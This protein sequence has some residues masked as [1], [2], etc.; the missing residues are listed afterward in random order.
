M[1]TSLYLLFTFISVSLSGCISPYKAVT[2]VG[3]SSL[4]TF[5]REAKTSFLG[6]ST[7]F[8]YFPESIE[9]NIGQGLTHG[10]ELG[11][12]SKG[13]PFLSN[14]NTSQL[15]VESTSTFRIY[16]RNGIGQNKCDTVTE[17]KTEAGEE[18]KIIAF[19]DLGLAF[20]NAG[21]SAK[22][23]K[24]DLVDN[25]FEEIGFSFHESC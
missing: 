8:V 21:C 4:I 14:T 22:L 20:H 2:D 25:R 24:K 23:Y 16:I 15:R 1:K 13:N 3:N 6:S 9:C 17:F 7:G 5:Q 12:L 10:Y 18:Y 19:S 11:V